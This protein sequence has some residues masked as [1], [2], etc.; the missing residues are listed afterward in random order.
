MGYDQPVLNALTEV[1][2][3]ANLL[4]ADSDVERGGFT[5]WHDY[6]LD[7]AAVTRI[8]D[9]LYGLVSGVRENLRIAAVHLADLKECR[10]ADDRWMIQQVKQTD[11]PP[12]LHRSDFEGRREARIDAHTAG[13]LRTVGSILD[14]LAGVV[15][16]VGGFDTA[17]MKADLGLLQPLSDGTS[18]PGPSVRGKLGLTETALD[19]ADQQGNL[20]RVTRSSIQYAGPEGWLDWTKWS[21]N[22]RVHR[23]SRIKINLFQPGDKIARPLPRQPEHTQAHAIRTSGEVTEL[24]LSEDSLTTLEG[25]LDSVNAAVVGIS[26]GC[27]KLWH[28]RRLHPENI[29]QPSGQ[30]PTGKSPRDAAF[31]GYR[32]GSIAPQNKSVVMISHRTDRRLQAAKVLDGDT[33]TA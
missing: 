29:M 18:Y 1:D 5:W 32:P 22:D 30:W 20:L 8:M 7:S 26:L 4:E 33:P 6:G 25:V 24:L 9:Y 10:F 11:R 23:A 2:K 27:A 28:Y 3:L 14:N 17:L 12:H 16:A 31:A 15:I 19:H 13:M 21:R